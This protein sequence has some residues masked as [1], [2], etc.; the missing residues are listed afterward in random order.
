VTFAHL[1]AIAESL[2]ADGKRVT[3]IRTSDKNAPESWGWEC[4][5]AA[6]VVCDV[7]EVVTTDGARYA[8]GDMNA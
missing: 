2:S 6:V 7:D 8:P 1:R 5:D 3:I 4:F